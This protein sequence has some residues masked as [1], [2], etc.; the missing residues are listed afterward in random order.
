MPFTNDDLDAI[1]RAIKSGE[2]TVRFADR[3]VTYRSIDELLRAYAVIKD[4]LGLAGGGAPD[5]F[6]FGATSKG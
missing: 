3:A 4:E 5:R 2:L 6:S 1:I